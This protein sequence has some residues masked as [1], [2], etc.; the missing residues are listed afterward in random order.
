MKQQGLK[1]ARLAAKYG[2]ADS[3]KF[4]VDVLSKSHLDVDREEAKQLASQWNIPLRLFVRS[5]AGVYVLQH[6]L[7]CYPPT[8]YKFLPLSPSSY[9]LLRAILC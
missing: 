2:D 5:G 9:A 6:Q 8:S 4:V 1:W 7:I 3:R